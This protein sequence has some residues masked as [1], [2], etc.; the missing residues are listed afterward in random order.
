MREN[1]IIDLSPEIKV[2]IIQNK[3]AFKY[4]SET[5]TKEISGFFEDTFY[6]KKCIKCQKEIN[7]L[8]YHKYC[9]NCQGFLCRNE[10]SDIHGKRGCHKVISKNNYCF[11][12]YQ[13]NKYICL[14]CQKDICNMCKKNHKTHKRIKRGELEYDIFDFSNRI[15]EIK[16]KNISIF[17]LLK[18]SVIPAYIIDEYNEFKNLNIRCNNF[19]KFITSDRYL[20]F[21]KNYVGLI[22]YEKFLKNE[23]YK[24]LPENI[25]KFEK[26]KNLNNFFQKKITYTK[27]KKHNKYTLGYAYKDVIYFNSQKKL[28]V[29][30]NNSYHS[31][32]NNDKIIYIY[33][34]DKKFKYEEIKFERDIYVP[35]SCG[36][37]LKI[38]FLEKELKNENELFFLSYYHKNKIKIIKFIYIENAKFYYDLYDEIEIKQIKHENINLESIIFAERKN[39]EL[40]FCFKDNKNTWIN[41]Y[42]FNKN[43]ASKKFNLIK[44]LIIDFEISNLL[45]FDNND[46]I[47]L[48]NNIGFGIIHSN[49]NE[50]ILRGGKFYRKNFDSLEKIQE[51][52]KINLVERLF[53]YIDEKNKSIMIIIMY[54]RIYFYN[55]IYKEIILCQELKCSYNTC[56]LFKQNILI[57]SPEDSRKETLFFK[58]YEDLK[59]TLEYAFI[60]DIHLSRSIFGNSIIGHKRIYEEKNK[61]LLFDDNRAIFEFSYEN[62]NNN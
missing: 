8:E 40:F 43:N 29:T 39:Y 62:K 25:I 23:L 16:Y 9:I 10:N 2:D 58:I 3:V 28:L 6:I 37:R 56:Y 11:E 32:E 51:E 35:C 31:D 13:Y 57:L 12:H 33:M 54:K 15:K 27:L 47:V 50:D 4:S 55:C 17:E 45:L 36:S 21:Q 1:Q 61:R 20:Y 52:E 19:L 41:I 44:S 22:N 60:N 46:I 38:E 53:N 26:F 42:K 5:I 24:F 7:I 49:E 18:Q 14:D 48:I 59:I 30:S 34:N